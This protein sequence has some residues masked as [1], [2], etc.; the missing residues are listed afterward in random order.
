MS[1]SK[2]LPSKNRQA[3]MEQDTAAGGL[4]RR[5]LRTRSGEIATVSLALTPGT[6][7]TR[8]TLRFKVGGSTIQR[9]VGVVKGASRA[10][11]LKLGWEMIRAQ[12]IV[13]KERWEWAAP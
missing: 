12:Q 9:P 8:V 13:E 6:G 5:K 10:E 7:G 1:E 3:A 11:A 4:A 2:V